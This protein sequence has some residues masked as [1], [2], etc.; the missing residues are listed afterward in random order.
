M[1]IEKGDILYPKENY[2]ILLTY[3]KP[4]EVKGTT[5]LFNSDMSLWIIDNQNLKWSFGQIDYFEPWD[6]FFFSEKEWTRNEKI[7]LL[8]DE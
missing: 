6:K 8:I 4:Y 3:G 1:I 5:L 2:G 7:Y